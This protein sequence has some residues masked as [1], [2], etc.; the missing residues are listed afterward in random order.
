M[1][2]RVMC[3]KFLN[4]PV[5]RRQRQ[6]AADQ[7]SRIAV[8]SA[9]PASSATAK[10]KKSPAHADTAFVRTLFPSARGGP[11]IVSASDDAWKVGVRPGMPLA[12]ARSMAAPLTSKTSTVIKSETLF[13]EWSPD[14]DRRELRDIAELTRRFA[15]IVGIDE[16]PVPDSLLLDITGCGPLLEEN[17]HWPNNS[18]IDCKNTTCTARRQS[19]IPWLRHGP[20]V[21][22]SGHFLQQTAVADRNRSQAFGSDWDLPIIVIP[23]GQSE[24]WLHKLPVAAGRIPLADAELLAQLGILNIRQLFELPLQDL[25]SRLSNH[26]ITRIHQLRGIEDELITP[27]PKQLRSPRAGFRIR[28]NE[29]HGNPPVQRPCQSP[30]KKICFSSTEHVDPAEELATVVNR[31]SNRLG[32]QA[33]LTVRSDDDPA[34]ERAVRL[35]SLLKSDV[36]V[37]EIEERL[38]DLTTQSKKTR[39]PILPPIVPCDFFLFHS[40]SAGRQTIRC[41]TSLDGT[42]RPA[43]RWPWRNENAFRHNG[44]MIHPS[45]ATTFVFAPAP[46]RNSGFSRISIPAAGSFTACSTSRLSGKPC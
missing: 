8:Y 30:D 36:G 39:P 14:S 20:F 23:P 10:R 38:S 16:T 43:Y 29:S 7:R 9:A 4:W 40:P 11:A 45:I 26:T 31:L 41:T 25:P 19:V 15:P 37:R 34:P 35:Q 6:L 42:D 27:I 12:E 44:G 13:F 32:R 28:S 22:A 21:H 18:F 24:S 33:V 2:K 46:D 17:R 5:Q 3:L 1:M